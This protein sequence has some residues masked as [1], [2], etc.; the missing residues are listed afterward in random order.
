MDDPAWW[1]LFEARVGC[2]FGDFRGTQQFGV[3]CPMT[4][5]Q[6]GGVVAA[7]EGWIAIFDI[8][9]GFLEMK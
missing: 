9:H 5:E 6:K 4:P 7:F 1:S 8:Q 2:H 3:A